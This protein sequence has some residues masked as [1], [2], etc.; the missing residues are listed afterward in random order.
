MRRVAVK[1][2]CNA[3]TTYSSHICSRVLSGVE[4]SQDQS[5]RQSPAWCR[6]RTVL[7]L[8]ARVAEFGIGGLNLDQKARLTAVSWPCVRGSREQPTQARQCER[9]D[10][11][12]EERENSRH[13]ETACTCAC[14]TTVVTSRARGIY[15]YVCVCVCVCVC[16]YTCVHTMYVY[17]HTHIYA[18][19][20]THTHT[21]TGIIREGARGGPRRR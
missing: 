11:R 16:T 4:C 18:S 10:S 7:V 1:D 17:I 21:V 19:T 6:T 3:S 9:Y 8:A 12:Y 5:G 20:H 15:V 13:E 2:H 14:C